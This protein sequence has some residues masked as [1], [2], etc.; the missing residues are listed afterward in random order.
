MKESISLQIS[1]VI[2]SIGTKKSEALNMSNSTFIETCTTLYLL[3]NSS[4][5]N[6]ELDQFIDDYSSNRKFVVCGD[7]AW[8][9]KK[10][11]LD[12][13]KATLKFL[14]LITLIPHIE[15]SSMQNCDFYIE[16]DQ[17]FRKF[18]L[19]F[20]IIDF[21]NRDIEDYILNAF[22]LNFVTL[23]EMNRS[24]SQYIYIGRAEQFKHK[25]ILSSNFDKICLE[26]GIPSCNVI[27]IHY[28]MLP[29]LYEA[30]KKL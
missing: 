8:R 25:T 21:K 12:A 28:K 1:S 14:L 7:F 16:D 17:G 6:S 13:K 19:Y 18:L 4:F 2:R 22:K 10:L 15:M 26:L 3:E 27:K 29:N 20:G 24:I 30:L 5:S 9:L 11:D 23:G